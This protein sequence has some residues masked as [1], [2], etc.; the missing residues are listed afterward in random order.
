MLLSGVFP[1]G[2]WNKRRT[3]NLQRY[4]LSKTTGTTHSVSLEYVCEHIF[5]VNDGLAETSDTAVQ[6]GVGSIPLMNI[7]LF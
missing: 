5:H 4:S 6:E 1:P 7:I 2:G 3:Q